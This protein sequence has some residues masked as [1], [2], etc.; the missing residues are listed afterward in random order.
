MDDSIFFTIKKIIESSTSL[1]AYSSKKPEAADRLISLF[2][3][4]YKIVV[5]MT[6]NLVLD[7]NNNKFLS[8]N[9]IELIKFISKECGPKMDDFLRD[10]SYLFIIS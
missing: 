5:K 9:F 6:K 10:V 7:P 1:I 2:V 8:K 4:L 3:K